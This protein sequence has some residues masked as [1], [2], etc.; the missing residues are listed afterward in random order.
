MNK[1]LYFPIAL[2]IAYVGIIVMANR[3]IQVWGVVEIGFGLM[4]P[5]GVFF[6]GL[7]FS[8]RD[9]LHETSNRNWIIS[10]ILIGSIVS[11]LIE[12]DYG[13]TIPGGVIPLAFASGLAFLFSEF[14]DYAVYSP[15]RK[16]G[17]VI[18]LIASNIVGLVLDSILFLYLA[19]GSLE[20]LDGQVVAKGY[21]TILVAIFM[22]L[23]GKQINNFYK[24]IVSD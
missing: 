22:I 17:K 12:G 7:A 9:G 15:L 13:N 3:A 20:F 21:M 8:V 18:A 16:T 5:A 10:A 24:S 23:L 14:A 4:A 19:F 1:N 11:F 6:A 2:T